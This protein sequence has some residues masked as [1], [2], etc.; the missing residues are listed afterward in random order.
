MPAYSTAEIRNIA[1]TGHTASGKTTLVEAILHRAGK[2][3]RMGSVEE[4][5]TVC[6]FEP[7][8]KDHQHSLNAAFVNIDH[9]GKNFDLV[10]TPGMPDFIGQAIGVMPAVETVAVV[11]GADKGIQTVTRRIMKIAGE[12]KLPRMIIVNKIDDHVNELEGLLYHIQEAFGTE[13]L[14]INL[15]TPDGTDV[16]DVWE[17]SDG[18]TAFSSADKAHT[19]ILDQVVELDEEL[20]AVYLEQGNALE[21][22]QLHD[23]F[24]QCLREAHIIP[25][26]FVSAKTGAG[27]DDLLHL[28]AELC[29]SPLEGNP[30]PFTIYENEGDEPHEWHASEDASADVFGHVFKI[31]T[32]PFVGKLAMVRIHQ[33]TLKP[34][35]SLYIGEGKKPARVAH[36]H[37]LQGK[38]HYEVDSAIPGDIIALAKIDDLKANDVLHSSHDLDHV[39]FTP[40]PLP[41][42]MFGLA[43]TAKSRNDET[44]MG[45]SLRKLQEEDPTFIVERIAATK[46]TVARGLGELH[47]RVLFERLKSHFKVELET[48]PPKVAYKETIRGNAEG[49]HR[50]KKQTGG[51]GQFGEVFLKVEPMINDDGTP[52]EGYEF[53]D[54][55]VGGSIPKG[56]MPAIDKGIR[57]AMGEGALA[58]YPVTGVRVR[59]YDGK[60]H[61]V[62]SKEIAFVTAGKRAF[63]DAMLKAKPALLEPIADIEV[64]APNSAMG[65]ITAD[66]SGKRGQVGQTDMLPGDMCLIHAKVP[67]AEMNAYS[68]QLKSITAGQG[69]FVMDYS[70]DEPCPP[71]VQEQVVKEAELEEV[72]A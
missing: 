9:E 32:D 65:D 20:M 11:I 55:T 44:K 62:D 38:E 10:D 53:V 21:K 29:P 56:F 49:H 1:I 69:S 47:L 25:V 52:A 37:K 58:G 57:Q 50:H 12:R 2:I 46:Q 45:E 33:G 40:L 71:N 14:P 68:A 70:H 5:N 59:V 54:E 64:T 19:A 8:E 6:D 31:T 27:L 42:P 72:E 17:R 28:M 24:E 3:G 35:D 34:G 4:K 43:V 67:L 26:L 36:I 22:Q 51:A 15:P 16:V 66:L 63:K 7:E 18:E 48:A 13:C 61:A 23:A 60:H 30:R 41:R 39:A